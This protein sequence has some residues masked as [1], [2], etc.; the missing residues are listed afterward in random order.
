MSSL[1]IRAAGFSTY[2]YAAVAVA[3]GAGGFITLWR[4]SR[5]CPDAHHPRTATHAGAAMLLGAS[6]GFVL[7]PCCTPIALAILA[8]AGAAGDAGYGSAL[9][10]SF[11]LGH[12]LP[13]I[14]LALGSGA[15]TRV[16]HRYAFRR[17]AGVVNGTLMLALAGYYGVLA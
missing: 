8:Y 5:E 2:T 9:M 17:A 16:F 12:A 6:F 4:G 13:L 1:L 10:A 11:A 14:A 3:L 15:F 7:S